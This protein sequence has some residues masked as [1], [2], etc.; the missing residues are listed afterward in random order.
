MTPSPLPARYWQLCDRARCPQI[1]P[2]VDLQTIFR[3]RLETT[4]VIMTACPELVPLPV[5]RPV[6]ASAI[7]PVSRQREPATKS[8]DQPAGGTSALPPD[9]PEAGNRQRPGCSREN[10]N[11]DLPCGPAPAGPWLQRTHRPGKAGHPRPWPPDHPASNWPTY[12]G[13]RAQAPT[14][15]HREFLGDPGIRS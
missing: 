10:G 11:P 2:V 6:T 8:A 3:T 9:N 5:I 13:V 7:N 15:R 4:G 12:A 1:L 14:G